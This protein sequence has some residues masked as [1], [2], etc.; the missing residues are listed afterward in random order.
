MTNRQ[1]TN[2]DFIDEGLLLVTMKGKLLGFPV[3]VMLLL[4]AVFSF[5]NDS[6]VEEWLRN[7]SVVSGPDNTETLS[8]QTEEQWIVLVIDFQSGTLDRTN[9]IESAEEMLIPQASDYFHEMSQGT[10]SVTVNIH[11]KMLVASQPLSYYGSD[12]GVER[13]SAAD[14]THMPM[15]LAEE[16]ITASSRDIDWSK[17]DLDG[18]KK[19]DRL[20]IL[21]TSVGQETGGNSNRI[22]SHFTTFQDPV[23]CLLYTSDAA[24][25]E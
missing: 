5:S 3:I 19:V 4:G 23:I 1:Q 9:M 25:E 20:L 11:N 2:Q 21:H 15:L 22:W 12:N 18:D 7:N 14:G 8:I 6:I 16:A 24:D 10:V 17:Y 13:D